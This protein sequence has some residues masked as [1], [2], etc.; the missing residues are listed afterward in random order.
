[1][2]LASAGDQPLKIIVGGKTYDVHVGSV[3][4]VSRLQAWLNLQPKPDRMRPDLSGM[5]V[6]VATVI[7]RQAREEERQWPP[8]VASSD[9]WRALCTSDE[10]KVM[11]LKIA[12]EQGH[13]GFTDEQAN[14]L[15][16]KMPNRVFEQ[17][18]LYFFGYHEM[19]ADLPNVIRAPARQRPME[20]TNHQEQ[21]ESV[22]AS[23]G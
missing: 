12:L 6:Q 18:V 23:T 17:V 16:D 7:A 2:D 10:G 9:G 22:N 11:L 20:P 5:P 1:M 4:Q 21:E 8:E 14:A 15:L 19:L 13:P 3:R